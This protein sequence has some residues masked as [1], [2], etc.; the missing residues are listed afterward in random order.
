M[1]GRNPKPKDQKMLEGTY[2]KD[3]DND[4]LVA[5]KLSEVPEAPEHLSD[6]GKHYFNNVC[7]TLE[8]LGILTG[9]DIY[10]VV[11]LASNLA[12][13]QEAIIEIQG[14]KSVRVAK[15][16]F[17]STGGWFSVFDKTSKK[18]MELSNLFGLSPSAR[19]R[20]RMQPKK[21]PDDLDKILG[22]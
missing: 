8:E 22:K 17:E 2:R 12:I 20:I 9:A 3:R 11:L 1:A 13:N 14:K 5:P 6:L 7:L 21:E 4:G 16:G 18:I 19:E 15:N 10:L